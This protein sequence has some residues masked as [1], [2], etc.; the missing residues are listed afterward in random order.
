MAGVGQRGELLSAGYQGVV[1]K[2]AAGP[3]YPGT[4]YLIIKQPMGSLL[5]RWFRRKMIRR[6]HSVYMRLAGIAGIPKCFGLRGGDQLLLEFIEGQPLKLSA[7]ELEDREQ[8]F[9]GLLSLL[10]AAHRVGVAHADLKRK[11]NI[12]ITSAGLPC[13]IDFGSAV[14]CDHGSGALRRWVFRLAC[15]IDLNAWVKH[16][17]LGR[18]AE[19]SSADMPYYQPTFIERIARP[20]RRFWRKVT[21]RQWRKARRRSHL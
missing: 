15:Q 6:E 8:F 14:T 9:S 2:V 3:E 12:L 7:D 13:L 16:K 21:A 19:I 17:Y 5:V 20:V 10:Q 18:Y 4:N 11:E 1:Y